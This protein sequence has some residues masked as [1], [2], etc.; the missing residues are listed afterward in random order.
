MTDFDVTAAAHCLNSFRDE[1]AIA[2]ASY[3]LSSHKR[4]MPK[5]D[6]QDKWPNI[7]GFLDVQGEDGR[8]VGKLEAQVKTLPLKH[9]LKFVCST[10]LLAYAEEVA[11]PPVLLLAVD[12]TA[13]KIYWMHLSRQYVR[14]LN[15]R[16]NK[17]TKTIDL[18]RSQYFDGTI[19]SYIDDW[20]G[21]ILDYKIKFREYE[22]NKDNYDLLLSVSNEAIGQTDDNI[23]PIHQF[24]D[25]LNHLLDY[26]FNIVKKIWYPKHWKVGI[27]IYESKPSSISYALYPIPFNKNDVQ[28]KKVNKVLHEQLQ[29]Q[30]DF[31]SV[32]IQQNPILKNPGEHAYELI[33]EKI[34]KTLE[35]RILDHAADS[36]LATEFIF[37]FIDK[38]HKQL[39]LEIR[40]IYTIEEINFAFHKFLPLWI[41]ET[42]KLIVEKERNG[43]KVISDCLSTDRYGIRSRFFDPDSL[44]SNI[45]GDEKSIVAQRVLM[46]MQKGDNIGRLYPIGNRKFGFNIFMESL[47]FLKVKNINVIQRLYKSRDWERLKAHG[48]WVYNIW[49]PADLQYNL[50]LFWHNLLSAYENIV[51]LNFGSIAKDLSFYR[52]TNKVFVWHSIKETY[53]NGNDAPTYGMCFLKGN[54]ENA[55]SVLSIDKGQEL[56]K[57]YQNQ[58]HKRVIQFNGDTYEL[59][60]GTNLVYSNLRFIYDEFPMLDFIY[61]ILRDRLKDYFKKH[62]DI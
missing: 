21:I 30:A 36:N 33:E 12:L 15:Y 19:K 61:S 20:I 6:S 52:E 25:K 38:F 47:A 5:L 13:K 16:K 60:E 62:N 40:D 31:F 51:E 57:I 9:N 32:Y 14:S 11:I 17:D 29:T 26:D 42:A 43:K 50:N 49:S 53:I 4:V 34:E 59:C 28:I 2:F 27:A 24:L 8:Q 23:I 7:D 55:L 22:E 44:A 3:I 45:L 56:A 10:A 35:Y 18:I 37:S 1:E 54:G 46:R 48:S 39:G 58:S 41:E